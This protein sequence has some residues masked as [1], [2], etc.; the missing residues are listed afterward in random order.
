MTGNVGSPQEPLA[1]LS[2]GMR[3]GMYHIISPHWPADTFDRFYALGAHSYPNECAYEMDGWPARL[4]GDATYAA[5]L[6]HKQ[7]IDPAGVFHC[8]HCVGDAE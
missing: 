7:A 6:A 5:L 2:P 4:W 1:A 3:S 8:R